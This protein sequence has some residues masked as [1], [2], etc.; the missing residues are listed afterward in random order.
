M[1][2]PKDAKYLVGDHQG[3][4]SQAN[5][6]FFSS[7]IAQITQIHLKRFGFQFTILGTVAWEKRAKKVEHF[8]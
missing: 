5:Q 6:M 2:Y 8:W 1:K 3:K 4:T 7:G